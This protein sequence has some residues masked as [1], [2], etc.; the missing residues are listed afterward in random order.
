MALN[1]EGGGNPKERDRNIEDAVE[2]DGGL[3]LEAMPRKSVERK[4]II[5]YE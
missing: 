4:G 5:A 1:V 2:N 3:V